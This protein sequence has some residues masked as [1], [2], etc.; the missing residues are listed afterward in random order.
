[1][2]KVTTMNRF[3]RWGARVTGLLLFAM[4]A[5][6]CELGVTNP[7]QPD[8]ERA[9]ATDSDVESLIVSAINAY[10]DV[11]QSN[12]D[13]VISE[14]DGEGT[15]F[16]A[17]LNAMADHSTSS[18]SN[19][20]LS[21][22][23]AEPRS[24]FPNSSANADTCLA[25]Q[26][27]FRAY[28]GLAAAASGL[29]AIA[30]GL[31]IGDGGVDTPRAQAF[32]RFAQGLL[33]GILGLI[34]DRAFIVTEETQLVDE[35]GNAVE[36]PFATYQEMQAE[37][38]R[39]L[40]EAISIA[41]SNTFTTPATWLNGRTLTSSELAALAH[42]YIARLE[43]RNSRDPGERSGKDWN[44]I[45]NH[46][47]QGHTFD[48]TVQGDASAWWSGLKIWGSG[49]GEALQLAMVDLKTVGPADQS[50]AYQA[51]VN[52]PPAQRNPFN[53][54]TS[55]QRIP[56]PVQESSPGV[57]SNGC[58]DGLDTPQCGNAPAYIG[59]HRNTFLPATR[60]TYQLSNYTR[61]EQHF[62]PLCNYFQPDFSWTGQ[63]C[64]FTQRDLAFLEA[65]ARWRTG[66]AQGGA[67]IINQFR[68]PE[69]GLPPATVNGVEGQADCVPKRPDGSC[70]N[71]LDVLV[72]EK[73]MA[74][75]LEHGGDMWADKR[76]WGFLTP[77]TAIHLP[78]PAQELE[79]LEL[80]IYTFGGAAGGAAPVVIPGD[81]TSALEKAAW[82]LEV[83]ESLEARRRAFKSSPASRVK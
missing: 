35:Q 52:S 83:L 24:T 17:V 60:G 39:L 80:D 62:G 20:G 49:G 77:G 18:W 51:W 10:W 11:S 63:V 78:V 41:S 21:R 50:G 6:A 47:G 44:A 31:E 73:G 34:F 19:Y 36:L 7:N 79:T 12:F 3:T 59:Y 56:D 61:Y 68:V 65:E 28:Q 75:A 81:L 76:G 74:V 33:H 72:Y 40:E 71:F 70:G 16:M 53:V 67:D 54:V 22:T 69:G 25:T 57:N 48:F 43:A 45:L 30:E 64:E 13:N 5:G 26:P 4:F 46:I 55:D 82:D 14:C 58:F 15:A 38:T 37:S 8:R 66:D 2:T 29:R 1:M 27:W 9:L 42:S 23:T 32:G